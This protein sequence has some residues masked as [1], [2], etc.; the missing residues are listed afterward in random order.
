MANK[1]QF[2][3]VINGTELWYMKLPDHLEHGFETERD[4]REALEKLVRMWHDQI[5]ESVG[6]RYEFL[7]LRFCDI[8]GGG[9]EEDWLPRYLLEPA[10]D[11]VPPDE[12]NV[13][14]ELTK[15]LDEAFGFD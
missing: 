4:F 7:R 10:P 13:V 14:D 2:Y 11:Y 12:R 3:R 9:S 8:P 1:R 5:G 15:E 6:E